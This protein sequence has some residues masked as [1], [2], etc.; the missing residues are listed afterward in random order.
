M[1]NNKIILSALVATL[2][3]FGQSNLVRAENGSAVISSTPKQMMEDIRNKAQAE[4]VSLKAETEKKIKEIKDSASANKEESKN[5]MGERKDVIKAKMEAMSKEMKDKME[6]MTEDFKKR[7]EARTEEM[8]KEIET[9]QEEFKKRLETV[10]DG[11]KKQ[12]VE[13]LGSQITE[14]NARRIQSFTENANHLNDISGKITS[15]ADK[16]ELSGGDVSTVRIAITTAQSL[17]ELARTAITTQA[18]NIYIVT[19]TSETNLKKDVSVVRHKLEADLKIVRTALESARDAIKK[20]GQTLEPVAKAINNK[21]STT[22]PVSSE[23]S[24]Q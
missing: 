1:K 5:M 3:F 10:K 14:L 20:A 17:M 4:R 19:I 16:V 18:G 8:K 15:R 2:A 9:R 24:N 22:T 7:I 11:R 21:V 6:A 12:T 23:N 13:K